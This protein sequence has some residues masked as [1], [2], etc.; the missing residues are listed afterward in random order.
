MEPTLTPLATP[1]P[2]TTG[3]GRGPMRVHVEVAGEERLVTVEPVGV[4]G[5]RFKLSWDATECVVDARRLRSGSLSVIVPA[6]RHASHEVTCHEPAPG[7][8]VLGFGGRHVRA[9]DV[10]L[11]ERPAPP[12]TTPSCRRCRAASSGCLSSLATR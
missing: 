11:L 10:V 7:E 8:L 3:A 4:D 12:V 9:G 2:Q 6:A 5:S 1:T